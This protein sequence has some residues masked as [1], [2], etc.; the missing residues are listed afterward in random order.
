[1]KKGNLSRNVQLLKIHVHIMYNKTYKAYNDRENI[2]NLSDLQNLRDCSSCYM[3]GVNTDM[4]NVQ[5]KY[6]FQ[7]EHECTCM[8]TSFHSST[9]C[10][11]LKSAGIKPVTALAFGSQV[12]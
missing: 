12:T 3:Y 5:Q 2:H 4:A 6:S 9:E 1:M 11:T 8:Y 7:L 10:T